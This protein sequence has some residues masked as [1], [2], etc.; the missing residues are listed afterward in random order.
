[1]LFR[2]V[3]KSYVE[4]Q[5]PPPIVAKLNAWEEG[6]EALELDV[7]RCRRNALAISA[8]P[9]CVFSPLDSILPSKDGILGDYSFVSLKMKN[10]SITTLSPIMDLAGTTE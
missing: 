8:H 7:R 5:R 3:W 6:K 10:K 4:A 1:M 2:S 9:F